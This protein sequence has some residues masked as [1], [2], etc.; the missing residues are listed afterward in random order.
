MIIGRGTRR[1]DGDL[2]LGPDLDPDPDAE[3]VVEFNKEGTGS[4][5]GGRGN[6]KLGNLGELEFNDVSEDECV[7]VIPPLLPVALPVPELVPTLRREEV[8]GGG[9]R[10]NAGRG[11][12]G[13]MI[14]RRAVVARTGY[15]GA[16]VDD[17]DG[18]V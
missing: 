14:V 17:A 5:I 3:V 2:D 15:W 9:T 12:E 4:V 18:G 11:G 6:M 10:M 7:S 16:V 8:R 1:S 13:A